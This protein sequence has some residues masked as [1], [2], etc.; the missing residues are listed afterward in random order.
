VQ[1][2]RESRR[3]RADN[4]HV[5]FELFALHIH[6]IILTESKCKTDMPKMSW[7]YYE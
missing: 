5:R 3:P 1:R 4:E 2:A 6:G 7:A